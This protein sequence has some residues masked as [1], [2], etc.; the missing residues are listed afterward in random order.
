MFSYVLH[1]C[2]SKPSL[3]ASMS[4]QKI[5]CT[6]VVFPLQDFLTESVLVGSF[7]V[8]FDFSNLSCSFELSHFLPDNLYSFYFF[9]LE[10]SFLTETGSLG[11]KQL[12]FLN[13][14][15]KEDYQRQKI[16]P[17]EK[18]GKRL[19][20]FISRIS[21][22]VIQHHSNHRGTEMISSHEG[23]REKKVL[24]CEAS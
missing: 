12:T 11:S 8:I 16:W 24:G 22:W 5:F 4:G 19:I 15:R 23:W 1:Q 17:P 20:S 18:L 21:L 13:E 7:H 6:F 9:K 10:D 2:I 3:K 14:E